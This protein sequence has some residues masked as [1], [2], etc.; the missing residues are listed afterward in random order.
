MSEE[1]Q[2]LPEITYKDVRGYQFKWGLRPEMLTNVGHREFKYYTPKLAPQ[3]TDKREVVLLLDKEYVLAWLKN[4][5]IQ[6]LG[7]EKTAM[8]QLISEAYGEN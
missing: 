4:V 7:L 5:L 8:M 3:G 2:P 1:P 6:P